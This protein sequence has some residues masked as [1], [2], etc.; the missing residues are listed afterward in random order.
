MA[1]TLGIQCLILLELVLK[2]GFDIC[3]IL[4]LR[5]GKRE[6]DYIA[7]RVGHSNKL[8]MLVFGG[9]LCS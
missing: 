8:V 9:E 2:P 1:N 5:I 6:T 3:L 7:R 4:T